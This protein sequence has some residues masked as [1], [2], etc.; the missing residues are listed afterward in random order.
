MHFIQPLQ[1]LGRWIREAVF[2]IRCVGCQNYCRQEDL[3]YLCQSCQAEVTI[4]RGSEC[5][6]CKA[7]SP[8][9]QTCALCHTS[10][11]VDRLFIAT[12]YAQPAIA[13]LI[14]LLKY[15][16][17]ADAA[18]TLGILMKQYARQ[19]ISAKNFN[20]FEDNKII[21][22]IPLSQARFRWRGFNQAQ[23]IAQSLTDVIYLKIENNFLLKTRQ[24]PPQALIADRHQRQENLR[25]AFAISPTAD[26][27]GKNILLIDDI[28]TTG[29]TLNECAKIL[30]A[31]G[32][33]SVSAFVAARES[34]DKQKIGQ[35]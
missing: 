2:P 35:N 17:A 29:A 9:G 18:Q 16:F 19:M 26:I 24:T 23:L 30:K 32:A 3:P 5:I 25:G 6:G 7:S 27:A 22:P 31:K 21:V 15:R 10:W 13:R 11:S 33:A 8:T 20:I 4:R 14:Q 1:H 34:W 28:C 12:D